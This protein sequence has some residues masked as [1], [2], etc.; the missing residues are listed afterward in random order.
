MAGAQDRVAVHAY[1]SPEAHK[2][3]QDFADEEGISLSGVLEAMATE[4]LDLAQPTD[5]TLESALLRVAKAGRKIDAE[6]RKR[7]KR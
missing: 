4:V 7:G 1:L 2:A 3:W 6:R 5:V